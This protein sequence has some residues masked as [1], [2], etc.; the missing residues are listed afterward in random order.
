MNACKVKIKATFYSF[1]EYA[2][3]ILF[4]RNNSQ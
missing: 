1:H 4:V 3:Q 2:Y